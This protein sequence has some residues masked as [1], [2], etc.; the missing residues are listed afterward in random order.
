M[1]PPF[2]LLG[3]WASVCQEHCGDGQAQLAIMLGFIAEHRPVGK[4]GNLGNGGIGNWSASI[5]ISFLKAR[6]TSD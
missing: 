2:V 4:D 1:C 3:A 5:Y 6:N